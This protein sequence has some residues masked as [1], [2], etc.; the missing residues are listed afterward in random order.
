[1]NSHRASC[2]TPKTFAGATKVTDRTVRNWLADK[3][4]PVSAAC[5]YWAQSNN[6]RD[7]RLDARQSVGNAA[8]A[9]TH[10]R[11]HAAR[12]NRAASLVARAAIDYTAAL[13]FVLR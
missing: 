13:F 3:N 8:V 12:R 10:L 11:S 7:R 4:L 1:M 2:W 5:R 9:F 6:A